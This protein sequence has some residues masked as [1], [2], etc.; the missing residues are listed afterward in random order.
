MDFFNNKTQEKYIARLL[1]VFTYI[2]AHLD[3]DVSLEAL[4]RVACFSPHHFHRIFRG[5]VGE[6]VKEHIRR[7][8][9]ERAA[10]KLKQTDRQI[11]QLAF[12]AGYET[13]ESFTRA[14]RDMFGMSPTRYRKTNRPLEGTARQIHYTADGPIET[15]QPWKK[16]IHMKVEVKNE[17]PKRVAFV[18]H[19]G[20]YPECTKAWEKL[21]SW[22]GPRGL[23]QPGVA[24]IG[25]CYDDPE[26]TP[27][28]KI[29]YDACITVD[30][31]VKAE[32]EI[33]IQEIPGGLYAMT[34]H[35]GSY[36]KLGETYAQLCGQWIPRNGYDHR[37]QPCHE[38]YLNSP[39][40][41]DE[42]ELLTDIYVPIEKEG[43]H[44]RQ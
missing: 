13:H 30:E 16:E 43:A 10:G 2:Q 12:E 19:I 1:K 31:T 35:H 41:T 8:K 36:S 37:S 42:A 26:V 9:L 3:E 17:S 25:L 22:A 33:G 14:F 34:T 29:R 6:S 38:V 28:E 39:E 21:C 23:F 44:G 11:I 7:I 27:P 5:I 32:G 20:P 4:A 18:R 40:D 24:F 15:F